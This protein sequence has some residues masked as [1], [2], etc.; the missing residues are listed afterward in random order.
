[1]GREVTDT[2]S[3][4]ALGSSQDLHHLH[5]ERGVIA[6]IYIYSYRYRYID[7][8]G[9]SGYVFTFR[10]ADLKHRD[11]DAGLPTHQ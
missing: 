10:G 8:M 2:E 7:R 3:L 9:G 11:P 1:M 6:L 4:H 5:S